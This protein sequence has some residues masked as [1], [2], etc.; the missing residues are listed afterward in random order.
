MSSFSI[1]PG[2]ERRRPPRSFW[3]IA[4]IAVNLVLIGLIF[5]WV[6]GMRAHQPLFGWQRDLI[7]SVSQAD[8]VIV[9]NAAD[10]FEEVQIHTDQLLVEQYMKLKDV[11]RAQPFSAAD[12]QKVLDEMAFIRDDQQ[13]SFQRIFAEEAAALSPEGR[14]KLVD[15]MER[16]GR[17]WH[18]PWH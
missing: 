12:C 3:L 9:G 13:I 15:A 14:L 5:S 4:S 2:I 10:R 18:P 16:E 7:G 6:I 1:A 8:A 11:L 17:R